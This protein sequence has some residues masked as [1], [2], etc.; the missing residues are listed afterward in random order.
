VGFSPD[1]KTLASGAGE[2][3]G[4]DGSGGVKLWDVSARQPRAALEEGG[5]TVFCV[6]F[7][8]DGKT[9]ASGGRN[10][11]LQLWDVASGRLI[12][13]LLGHEGLVRSVVFHPNG[14]TIVSVG[15]DGTIRFWAVDTGRESRP[16]ITL[17][18]GAAN[19]VVITPNGQTLAANTAASVGQGSQ[20][21]PDADRFGFVLSTPGEIKLWDWASGKELMTLRGCRGAI[22]GLA[23]SP[24]GRFLASAGGGG[25]P[26]CPGE[27][28]LWD[29][30]A[31]RLIADLKGH[32]AWVE[33][34]AFSPDG[35]VLVSAGGSAHGPG[36]LKLWNLRTPPLQDAARQR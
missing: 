26:A 20:P 27:V 29:I 33:T 17:S 1:G 35:R 7:S 3:Q 21:R 23:I 19:C 13:S 9:L 8:P 11:V 4:S 15:F 30:T 10:Q 36:E 34:V 22:L 5:Q 24:D 2:W 18:S 16:A 14:R 31:G 6:A 28:K 32:R 12:R 25:N